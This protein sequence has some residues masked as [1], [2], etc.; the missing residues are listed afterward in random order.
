MHLI[1]CRPRLPLVR[2]CVLSSLLTARACSVMLLPALLLLL[3]TMSADAALL[4]TPYLSEGQCNQT[5]TSLLTISLPNWQT[6]LSGQCVPYTT[7]NTLF[8]GTA[9]SWLSVTCSALGPARVLMYY[10]SV[11]GSCPP[12]TIDFFPNF[13]YTGGGRLG[14]CNTL[15]WQ[16]WWPQQ[17]TGEAMAVLRCDDDINP[18]PTV[19]RSS[20][21]RHAQLASTALMLLAPIVA[22]VLIAM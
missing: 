12:P 19:N 6:N 18:P 22:W 20:G 4:V 7:P 10:Y 8:P 1:L 17:D 15:Y 21:S 11:N 5:D 13:T 14:Q 3:C 2:P 9:P 16:Q